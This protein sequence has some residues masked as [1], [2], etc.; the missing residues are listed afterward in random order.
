MKKLKNHSAITLT[1]LVLV[2]IIVGILVSFGIPK[3][4]KVIKQAKEKDAILN[5]RLIKA[6]QNVYRAEMGIFYPDSTGPDDPADADKINANLKL[7]IM[8]DDVTYLCS[9]G[10]ATAFTCD[11]RDASA[12]W[13]YKITAALT[14][15]ACS[16]GTCSY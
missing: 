7:G 12:G 16:A 10:T 14:A 3:Y 9:K 6:A 8:E 13:Q 15:P 5:L 1:E 2:V 11:A 4:Q